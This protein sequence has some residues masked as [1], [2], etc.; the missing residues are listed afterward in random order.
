MEG[1]KGPMVPVDASELAEWEKDMRTGAAQV[2][3]PPAPH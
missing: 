3:A 2:P 1:W